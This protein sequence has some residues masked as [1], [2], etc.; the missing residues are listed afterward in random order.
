MKLSSVCVYCGS[1]P[2]RLPVYLQSAREL[3]EE[4]AKR[5]I[6][7]VYGGAKVGLMGETARVALAGGARVTGVIPEIIADQEIAFQGLDELIVVNSMHERKAKMAELVDGFIAMPGGFGTFDEFFE[8]LTW[9]QL[10]LH[11]K[12]CGLLNVANYFDQLLS[13]LDRAV[14]D[15]FIHEPHRDMIITAENPRNLID[16]M[17]MYDKAPMSKAEWVRAMRENHE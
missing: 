1:S 14:E 15:K 11:T 7:L 17:S 12:P 9:A 4:I 5:N 13:F 8:A 16:R 6:H 2:G 10:G 3:G